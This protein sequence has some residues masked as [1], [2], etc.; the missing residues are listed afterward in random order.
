MFCSGCVPA[1]IGS[2]KTMLSAVP[3]PLFLMV[4]V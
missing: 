1:G 3:D 2:V 4:N